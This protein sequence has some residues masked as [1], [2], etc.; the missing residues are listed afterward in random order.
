VTLTGAN[1][2]P[3]AA[4]TISGSGV[5]AAVS[6]DSPTQITAILTVAAN[7]EPI[8][9]NVSVSSNGSGS[10]SITFQIR[11]TAVMLE[12][13]QFRRWHAAQATSDHGVAFRSKGSFGPHCRRRS[14][15]YYRK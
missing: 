3:G 5:T 14:V 6:V 11:Q 1:F 12:H 2:M 4:V 7:A 9:R 13:R 15:H 10:N 8:V